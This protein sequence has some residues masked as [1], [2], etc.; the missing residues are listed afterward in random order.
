M[1]HPITGTL[2]YQ[3]IGL[4]Q[5]GQVEPGHINDCFRGSR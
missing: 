5:L 1:S 3:R 4:L 2:S